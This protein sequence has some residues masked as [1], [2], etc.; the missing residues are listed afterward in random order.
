MHRGPKLNKIKKSFT[1]RY[2]LG[3]EGVAASMAGD[4]CPIVTTVTPRAFYWPFL[5]WN[6]YDYYNNLGMT[7]SEKELK[8]YCKKQD[9]F[10]VLAVL[11]NANSDRLNLV[12]SAINS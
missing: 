1:T 8:K 10:F 7:P 12:G 6:Y 2:S 3:I 5:I 11:L 4:I 9:Y